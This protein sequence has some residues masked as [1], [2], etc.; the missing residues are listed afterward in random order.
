LAA[1][2]AL[3]GFAFMDRATETGRVLGDDVV[4]RL[5]R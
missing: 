3:N 2:G 1:E 4:L 5:T